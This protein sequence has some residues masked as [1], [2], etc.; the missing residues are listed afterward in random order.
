MDTGCLSWAE[1]ARLLQEFSSSKT[2]I[3]HT[4]PVQQLQ[5]NKPRHFQI[6]SFTL[7]DTGEN[8]SG[9]T[10]T[11]VSTTL[12]ANEHHHKYTAR[13][14]AMKRLSQ[15]A[16]TA[17]SQSL[18]RPRV[19]HGT[20]LLSCGY[21]TAA[22]MEAARSSAACAA[23]AA[24]ARAAAAR[25]TAFNARVSG[26]IVKMPSRS[27]SA[28]ADSRVLAVE[29]PITYAPNWLPWLRM[30]TTCFVSMMRAIENIWGKFVDFSSAPGASTTTKSEPAGTSPW[31]TLFSKKLRKGKKNLGN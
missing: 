12:A 2:P 29:I 18:S 21:I 17:S 4:V 27:S 19:Y 7:T 23:A 8:Q 1:D 31:K 24:A 28:E 10:T 22:A 30:P 9:A 6:V 13:A 3:N 14:A 26:A 15:R 25:A 20:Y 16:L 5:K 11:S